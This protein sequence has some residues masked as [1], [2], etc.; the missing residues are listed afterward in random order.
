MTMYLEVWRARGPACIWVYGWNGIVS[1]MKTTVDLPDALLREAQEAARAEGTTVK[2]LIETGLRTVLA[3]R[4]AASRFV[5]RDAS[6]DGDGLQ[7][8]FRQAGWEQIRETI[9]EPGR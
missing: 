6:V 2:A 3:R 5:L 7:P 9:Y 1:H 8:E 4:A